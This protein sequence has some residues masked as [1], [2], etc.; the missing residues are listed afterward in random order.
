MYA[1]QEIMGGF[2]G[3]RRLKRLHSA[4]L[5]VHRPHDMPD[6]SVLASGIH[7]LQADQKRSLVFGIHQVLQIAQLVLILC[8]LG[9]SRR[10]AFMLV[11]KVRINI[12]KFELVSRLNAKPFTVIQG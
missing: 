3:G 5:R 6:S 1:P 2:F 12:G 11:V 4:A 9:F 7:R 10:L 8:D